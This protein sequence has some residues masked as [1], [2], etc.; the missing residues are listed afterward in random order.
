MRFY[1]T[2]S[3]KA[4]KD[5]NFDSDTYQKVDVVGVVDENVRIKDVKN[6]KKYKK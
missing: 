6:V 4:I 5:P 3:I 1:V 2:I